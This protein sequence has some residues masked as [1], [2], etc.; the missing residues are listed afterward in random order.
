M[1]ER[2]W[3]GTRKGGDWNHGDTVRCAKRL[4]RRAAACARLAGMQMGANCC[5]CRLWVG[6]GARRRGAR[7]EEAVAPSFRRSH[8]VD[9]TALRGEVSAEV[10]CPVFYVPAGRVQCT[11]TCRDMLRRTGGAEC[12]VH[13]AEHGW[14]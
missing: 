10:W 12:T 2:Y 11:A 1:K 13:I 4:A 8:L 6:S 14:C 9:W 3:G 7:D 5:S